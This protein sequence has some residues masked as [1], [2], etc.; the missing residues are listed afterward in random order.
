MVASD[1]LQFAQK[2][3]ERER[4]GRGKALHTGLVRLI[5]VR[6]LEIVIF[7]MNL[8]MNQYN[9]SD[10]RLHFRIASQLTIF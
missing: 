4:R 8:T 1:H 6:L 7:A 10:E 9:E 3:N 2:S 5:F